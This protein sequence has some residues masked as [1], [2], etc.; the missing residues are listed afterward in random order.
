MSRPRIY[1]IIFYGLI[2]FFLTIA[3]AYGY[4]DGFASAR[5]IESEHFSIL[6]AAQVEY[7]QLA[8]RLNMTQVDRIMVDA[9]AKAGPLSTLSEMLDILFSRVCNTLDMQLYSFK[10]NIKICKDYEQLNTI[11][12]NLFS[13]DLGGMVSFYV[14]DLN[15]IYVSAGSFKREVL[16]HEIAHAV[17]SHYFVVQPPMKAQEVL[18][19]Y[20][21]YQLRE[22]TK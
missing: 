19:G 10:G 16:G 1:N 4:D 5:K 9:D 2:L 14:Y 6:L 13:K 20:V 12:K 11:Y 17:I 15:T 21:E 8:Q 3:C 7:A 18:A 22:A